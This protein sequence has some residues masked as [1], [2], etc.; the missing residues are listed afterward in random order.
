MNIMLNIQIPFNVIFQIGTIAGNL[1]MKK[2]HPDFVSDV[3]VMLETVGAT[4][5]IS[6]LYIFY[7]Q[8]FLLCIVHVCIL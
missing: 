6:E 1:V 3:Y 8:P 2:E 5:N 7:F 4:L